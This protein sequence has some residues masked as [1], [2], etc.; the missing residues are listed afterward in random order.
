MQKNHS[1]KLTNWKWC[2]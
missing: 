1:S 2:I